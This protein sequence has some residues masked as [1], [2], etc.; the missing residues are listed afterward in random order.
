MTIQRPVSTQEGAGFTENLTTIATG[1]RCRRA[2]MSSTD[3]DYAAS[4]QMVA[5][6]AI[7]VQPTTNIKRDDVLTLDGKTF[8]VRVILEPSEE[9]YLKALAEQIQT[10]L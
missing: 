6:H 5:N 10:G 3:Q 2:P 9:L 7:W 4:V 1:V 8:E